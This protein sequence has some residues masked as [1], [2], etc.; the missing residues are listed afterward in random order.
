MILGVLSGLHIFGM[1]IGALLGYFADE[2][3]FTRRVLRRSA[4][5]IAN[6]EVGLLNETWTRIVISVALACGV[7]AAKVK[8]MTLSLGE[9]KLL[10]DRIMQ[11]LDSD[12]KEA[13]LTRQII[14]LIFRTHTMDLMKLTTVYKA[15]S[16]VE[17]REVLLSLL[18]HVAAGGENGRISSGQNN[19]LKK[20]SI[21]LDV[22]ASVYNNI[23]SSGITFDTEAYEI[24]GLP[25]RVSDHEIHRVY[26]KLAAHFHPDGAK[27]LDD[28][29]R[30]Q[31]H[32]AFLKIQD[33][34]NRIIA[35]RSALRSQKD[36]EEK[37]G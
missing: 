10:E 30:Q 19:I 9:R 1:A 6:P 13:A 26:R 8:D 27:D 4:E 28:E 18:V 21:E 37:N 32:E 34:Y 33:A 22:S 11:K 24:L 16:T 15:S 12:G 17:E 3:M 14:E 5:L 36:E 31:A 2:L 35:D 7:A 23:R 25:P 29:Q 20:V